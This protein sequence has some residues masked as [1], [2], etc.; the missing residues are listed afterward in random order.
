MHLE[1]PVRDEAHANERHL[2]MA[3]R[4]IHRSANPLTTHGQLPSPEARFAERAERNKNLTDYRQSQNQR[5][6]QDPFRQA[7]VKNISKQQTM[8]NESKKRQYAAVTQGRG[9]TEQPHQVAASI[10]ELLR[11]YDLETRTA[12]EVAPTEEWPEIEKLVESSTTT[13]DLARVIFTQIAGKDKLNNQPPLLTLTQYREISE[14]GNESTVMLLQQVWSTTFLI[15]KRA[16]II[17]MSKI[18]HIDPEERNGADCTKPKEFIAALVF[19]L[20]KLA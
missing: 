10:T 6:E 2:Q 18:N 20:E 12:V 5:I 4:S 9:R 8:Q 7:V 14:G 13:S 11:T 3:N 1:N 15:E 16:D 17:R 19:H